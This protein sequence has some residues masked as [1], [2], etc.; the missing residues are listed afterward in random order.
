MTGKKCFA[1]FIKIQLCRIKKKKIFFSATNKNENEG[2][3]SESFNKG[4]Q[5]DAFL[6]EFY[7]NKQKN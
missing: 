5:F 6:F 7:Q 2:M 1:R 3:N 4:K